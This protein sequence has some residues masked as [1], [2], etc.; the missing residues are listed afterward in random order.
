VEE[1][2]ICAK[3]DA[4]ACVCVSLCVHYCGCVEKVRRPAQ[5]R[6]RAAAGEQSIEK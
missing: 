6:V 4:S 2:T 5:S 3:K 1:H